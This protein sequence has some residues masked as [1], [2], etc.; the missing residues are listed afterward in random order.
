MFA[1]NAAPPLVTEISRP[2]Y[3]TSLT[4]LYNSLWYSGAIVYVFFSR[5][6]FWLFATPNSRYSS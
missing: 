4:S 1:V 6:V 5:G 3:R 2:T